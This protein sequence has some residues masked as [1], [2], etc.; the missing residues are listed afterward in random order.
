MAEL[1]KA[2][3]QEFGPKVR[4]AKTIGM[5]S[6]DDAQTAIICHS[7]RNEVYH[8]GAIHEEIL[9]NLARFYFDR[10]CAIVGNY[11]GGF[12]G[13]SSR[14]VLP[15]RAERFFTGHHLFPG[16]ASPVPP[17]LRKARAGKRL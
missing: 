17:G 15:K 4:F 9:P 8:V 5:L 13:W 6:D 1:T 12:I 7:F 16:N 10:A 11:K 14:D 2:L 3:A